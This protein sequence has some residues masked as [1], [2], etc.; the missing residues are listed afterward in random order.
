MEV[1]DTL[2]LPEPVAVVEAVVE[3]EGELDSVLS[4]TKGQHWGGV[5]GGPKAATHPA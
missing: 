4:N 1:P 5:C 2:G 3:P